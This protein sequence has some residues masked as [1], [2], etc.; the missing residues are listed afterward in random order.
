MLNPVVPLP[1]KDPSLLR[2]ANYL[3]GKW[4]EADGG[5]TIVVKNPATGEAI[6]EVPNMGTTETRRAIWPR[7]VRRSCANWLT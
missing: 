5:Q 6:G 2:Q 7:N 4:I 3:D 1:L